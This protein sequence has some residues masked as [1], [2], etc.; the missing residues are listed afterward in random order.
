MSR[1]K[2][3]IVVYISLGETNGAQM[4]IYSH[5]C[6]KYIKNIGIVDLMVKGFQENKTITNQKRIEEAFEYIKLN[7]NI[8][9]N[10]FFDEKI[11]DI[12]SITEIHDWHG[13][14]TEKKYLTEYD[15]FDCFQSSDCKNCK[16]LI[17]TIIFNNLVPKKY[18]ISFNDCNKNQLIQSFDKN[19]SNPELITADFLKKLSKYETYCTYQNLYK[20]YD[21]QNMK[22]L[23]V[24]NNFLYNL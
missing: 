6:E 22:F 20:T 14:L 1:D 16:V 24:P 15:Y 21:V 8:E 4:I 9:T 19:C 2:L 18:V 10:S 12:G 11:F 3:A 5:P 13:T 23:V 7:G 17:L